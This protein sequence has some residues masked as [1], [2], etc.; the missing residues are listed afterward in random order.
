MV[1]STLSQSSC[2]NGVHGFETARM[3]HTRSYW[4]HSQST[5]RDASLDPSLDHCHGLSMRHTSLGQLTRSN[6]EKNDR[7]HQ[8]LCAVQNTDNEIDS[9]HSDRG[10]DRS[11]LVLATVPIAWGS[12]EPAVRLVYKYEPLMPPLVFSFAYYL[13]ATSVL[14]IGTLYSSATAAAAP[15]SESRSASTTS[16][17][18]GTNGDTIN[19][20]DA[21]HDATTKKDF[22]SFFSFSDLPLST[23]G[24]I[25]LGTY[26]FIGNAFQVIGLKTV[27]SD[28]AAFLLQLTTIFV[29][30][31]KSLT[32]STVIPLQ[33]WI[34][35]LVAL[36]GV[37]LIG[38]DDGAAGVVSHNNNIMDG[39]TIRSYSDLLHMASSLFDRLPAFSVEDGYI[40]L[41]AVFYTFHC[42][43]LET[44]A[45]STA[46][47]IGLA[48]AKATTE[49]LWSGVLIVGCIFA[50][51]AL[52]V[53]S[54]NVDGGFAV[55]TDIISGIVDTARISGERIVAYGEGIQEQTMISTSSFPHF[56]TSGGWPRVGLATFWV[57]AVTVAYTIYA[58]SYGQS[59]VTAV[60]A[61]LIYSSQPIF[62]AMVAYFLL[63]ESL[64]ANGY[65]G[66]M[67]IGAAVLLVIAAEAETDEPSEMMAKSED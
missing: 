10:Y 41:A 53:G 54:N 13:V 36:L 62:T 60:T 52:G 35:C 22:G 47:A 39:N 9:S 56:F 6:D 63:G 32:A 2:N 15:V 16:D 64:G 17:Q 18:D 34:A 51:V 3:Q 23:R 21:T 45:R 7:N 67:L 37:A 4:S 46:S 12:F 28:R 19:I 65:I 43:R 30:L 38:L 57:G 66:G 31:L 40:V 8:L 5:T 44:Y 25:E 14:T 29:P 33:T 42:I 27:P 11:L 20:D 26:L 1:I 49:M 59:R 55:S 58:Q 61:N 48:T 24:G 50:A